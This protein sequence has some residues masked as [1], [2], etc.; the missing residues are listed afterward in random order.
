MVTTDKPKNDPAM[1]AQ[2][3]ASQRLHEGIDRARTRRS[4]YCSLTILSMTM[5]CFG[6]FVAV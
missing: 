3:A 6:T 2:V 5:P 1:H 4:C